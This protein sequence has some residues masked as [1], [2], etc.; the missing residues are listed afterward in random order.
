MKDYQLPEP[1]L[2][3]FL[4]FHPDHHLMALV[5]AMN[6][7][8]LLSCLGLDARTADLE[9]LP[10]LPGDFTLWRSL[11]KRTSPGVLVLQRWTINQLKPH[12]EPY[13]ETTTE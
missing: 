10:P 13:W 9:R 5:L 11:E 2:Y 7:W 12:L 8:N 3:R 4:I 6:E 1:E